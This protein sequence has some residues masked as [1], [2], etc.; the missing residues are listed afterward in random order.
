MYKAKDYSP[1]IGLP[2]FSEV[3]LTNHFTLYQGYVNNVN[4]I[5]ELLSEL[6]GEGKNNTPQYAE[7]KRRFGWEFNGMRLHEL[8]F[9]NLTKEAKPLDLKSPLALKLTEDFGD[10]LAWEK[11]FRATGALRGVGW[12]VLAYDP[13]GHK[14][15]NVWVNEHDV[16]LLAGATPLLVLDVFEHAYMLD[17]GLKRADYIA[18]FFKAINWQVAQEGFA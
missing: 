3:L 4:L 17:F 7:A 16:G 11:E 10:Y 13:V 8:Y 14:T 15:F 1:L 6:S 12:A 2:G 18:A 5:A 9:D